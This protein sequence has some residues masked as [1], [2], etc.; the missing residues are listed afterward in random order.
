VS[1][2]TRSLPHSSRSLTPTLTPPPI[3]RLRMAGSVSPPPLTG[4]LTSLL[5]LPLVLSAPSPF[6]LHCNES[7]HFDCHDSSNPCIPLE[8]ICDRHPD[9][10]NGLDEAHCSYLHEC[11]ASQLMCR[12][13]ECIDARYRCDRQTDCSD[14]SDEKG[15]GEMEEILRQME[16]G[17]LSPPSSPFS[18]TAAPRRASVP[19]LC[20]THEYQCRNG[21]CIDEDAKC[22]GTWDCPNGDDEQECSEPLT[23]ME[24]IKGAGL[25]CKQGHDMCA[26]QQACIP[27][28]WKCDGEPD[29]DDQSDEAHCELSDEEEITQIIQEKMKE[30][31][32][33]SSTIAD[34]PSAHEFLSSAD[35]ILCDAGHFRCKGGKCLN[36]S[37]ACDGHV[38]CP[39]GDDES[40]RCNECASRMDHKCSHVCTNSPTGHHCSCPKGMILG[41]DGWTCEDFDECL[42][43][44]QR[45]S[46]YC[47][48]VHDGYECACADGYEM[49]KDRHTCHVMEKDLDGIIYVSLAAEIRSAPMFSPQH[50][51]N[52]YETLV[53]TNHHG[54]TKNLALHIKEGR[55]FTAMEPKSHEGIL[56]SIEHGHIRKLRENVTGINYVA[57][58]WIGDN[59]LYTVRHPSPVP[60]IY[61]CKT[62]GLYCK[63]IIDGRVGRKQNYR[64]LAVNPLRGLIAYI[65]VTERDHR[66]MVANMDG[67]GI[68]P[69]VDHKLSYPSGLAFDCIKNE[70]YFSDVDTKLIE[71]INLDTGRR[72]T[73]IY[74]VNHP[75]DLAFFNN[76]IYWTEWGTETLKVASV[77][78]QHSTPHLVHGFLQFPYGIALNHTLVQPRLRSNP[79]SGVSCPW[80][81]V[82]LRSDESSSSSS[83]EGRC[84]CP[85]EYE[86]NGDYDPEVKDSMPCKLRK[87][88]TEMD[89]NML[90]HVSVEAMEEYCRSGQVC[91]NGGACVEH[92]NVHGRVERIDCK[93]ADGYGGLWCEVPP[94]PDADKLDGDEDMNSDEQDGGSTINVGT[95]VILLLLLAVIGG[96]V[97]WGSRNSDEITKI[98]RS[99]I[100]RVQE[101]KLPAR[102]S[103]AIKTTSRNLGMAGS[104]VNSSSSYSARNGAEVKT[105]SPVPPPPKMYPPLPT[106]STT[107]SSAS[108]VSSS[109]AVNFS[110][111]S[112]EVNNSSA[113]PYSG[114]E[115]MN[116]TDPSYFTIE[117]ADGQETFGNNPF[118]RLP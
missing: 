30:R 90:S 6:S 14:G 48:N 85:D 8:W 5:L 51:S 115:E 35:D 109:S 56:A 73:V 55:I 37:V 60:G 69:I 11:S 3:T 77:G 80:M 63:K 72:S 66:I 7:L 18:T 34:L 25:K 17:R 49:S 4:L 101:A 19:T 28:V 15:C 47:R 54:T 36:I 110:N 111:P 24:A 103:E 75:Y 97:Y 83:L 29:C 50:S 102:A 43:D 114:F 112:F 86:E 104:T 82:A 42:H 107:S 89:V 95:V 117:R 31:T 62:S 79:C 44:G 10:P 32:D 74:P 33:S 64:G 92:A 106:R 78:A 21:Q 71:K 99:T 27:A 23:I 46:Q 65:D 9:C 57:V 116:T 88:V 61:L 40:D 2:D 1:V 45:C 100:H 94:L 38:D 16:R 98:T 13:G 39:L 59:V 81:C 67:S 96:L 108:L 70:V 22:D 91:M 20:G 105:D 58:D 87:D 113:A 84:V 26:D 118:G 76:L 68:R 52:G 93:C 41:S 53:A 12:N